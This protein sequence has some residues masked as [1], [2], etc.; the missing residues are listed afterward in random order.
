MEL[1]IQKIAA[2]I[3]QRFEEELKRLFIEERD[4]SEYII[5]TKEMLDEV[6]VKLVAEALVKMDEAVR[7]S[8]DRKRN[9]VIKSKADQKN[10]ATIFGEVSYKR[11]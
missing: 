9:W 3:S 11:T 4:I 7:N 2:T 10:L 6:G 1:I 5:A 8:A